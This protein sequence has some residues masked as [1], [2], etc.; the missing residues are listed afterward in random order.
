MFDLQRLFEGYIGTLLGEQHLAAVHFYPAGL[1][2]P[3]SY[4]G[5]IWVQS[6]ATDLVVFDVCVESFD[7]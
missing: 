5:S 6:S 3:E 1:N 4:H 2:L 7:K